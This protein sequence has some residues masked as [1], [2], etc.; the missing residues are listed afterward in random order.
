MSL[1]L[2][3]KIQLSEEQDFLETV[4]IS[5]PVTSFP[6]TPILQVRNEV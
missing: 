2:T 4:T 5:S 6:A 1:S 3:H